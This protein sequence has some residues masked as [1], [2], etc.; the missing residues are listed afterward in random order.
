MSKDRFMEILNEELSNQL[1]ECPIC[2]N[3]FKDTLDIIKM[4]KVC[5]RDKKIDSILNYERNC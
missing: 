4:C 1:K 5:E 2:K 3:R